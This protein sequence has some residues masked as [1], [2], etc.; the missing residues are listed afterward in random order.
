M[1]RLILIGNGFDLSHGL[2]TSYID[3]VT[4][5]FKNAIKEFLE[6]KHYCD[7]LF[8]LSYENSYRYT[9]KEI[10]EFQNFEDIKNCL[11]TFQRGGSTIPK[12]NFKFHS[13]FFENLF[14]KCSQLNWVDIEN[15]Y[16][17]CLLKINKDG[18]LESIKKLNEEFKYLTTKLEDYLTGL[19]I[20]ELNFDSYSYSRLFSQKIRRDDIVSVNLTEDLVPEIIYF[21]NFNY[22][23]TIDNYINN[24]RSFF[25][26]VQIEHNF[27]HGEINSKVNP[28]IFGFGDELN[29][30]YLEFENLRNTDLFTHIKS[31]KYSVTSNYHDL[32]KFVKSE[33]FQVF[34]VGH[35]CGLSDRT[36]LSQIF[37]HENCKSIKIFYYSRTDGTDDFTEK[38]Y[39][40]SRHFRN[41]GEM[42]IQLVSK[43][44][45]TALPKPSKN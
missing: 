36:M 38:T 42:R 1:N 12:V 37:E 6:K 4:N 3:F 18:D 34:I 30:D 23:T 15:E 7:E 9:N 31:F 39:E 28:L 25:K 11:A 22:T 20:G 33:D 21:L 24:I 27:I 44:K 32:I 17:D 16:F 29:E 13:K 41:K 5:Y 35:S 40:I 26:K 2:K 10:G 45:S 8:E 14:E 19:R 43:D